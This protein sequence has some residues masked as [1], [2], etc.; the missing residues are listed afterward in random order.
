[1]GKKMNYSAKILSTAVIARAED[2][3]FAWPTIIRRENGELLV[4]FSGDRQYHCCPYGKTMLIR[5]SDNGA[6]WSEPEVI[7]DTPLDDRDAGILETDKGTL[8]LSHFTSIGFESPD[9][10]KWVFP[11]DPEKVHKAIASWQHII[12]DLSDEVRDKYLGSCL[13]R[14]TDG[15]KTWSDIQ[16]IATST[17]HGPIKLRD[18]RLLYVGRTIYGPDAEAPLAEKKRYSREHLGQVE[19]YESTDDGLN[20]HKI[21]AVPLNEEYKY[22][23]E[24][25]CVECADGRLVTFLRETIMGVSESTDGGHTWSDPVSTGIAGFPPHFYTLSNGKILLV[26]SCRFEPNGQFARISDD[27]GRSWSERFQLS[28]APNA[29]HGYPASTQLP[30]G[31]ILTVYYEIDRPGEKTSI[32]LVHWVLEEN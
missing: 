12:D 28:F 11:N 25:Y 16:R 17:P 21:G 6:T 1:M 32:K 2:K 7:T 30:D 19:I 8:L 22:G 14:S 15:G 24:P 27:N 10:M 9:V 13:R 4:V 26:Y 5:S 23:C 3:Y 20:W 31:S 29:D 18:G